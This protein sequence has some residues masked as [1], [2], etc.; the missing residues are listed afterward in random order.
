[1]I[2]NENEFNIAKVII[3]LSTFFKNNNI[4]DKYLGS[5]RIPFRERDLD[6]KSIL[7]C[8]KLW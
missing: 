2:P 1:M 4:Q 5:E 6:Y 7:R 3:P 8:Y